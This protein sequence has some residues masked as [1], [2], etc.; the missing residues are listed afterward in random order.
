VLK[1]T[2]HADDVRT[3]GEAL[4]ALCGGRLGEAYREFGG[5]L[6]SA[7]GHERE[8]ALYRDPDPVLRAHTPAVAAVPADTPAQAWS[9]L[10]EDLR[11]AEL[12]DAVDRPDAWTDDH[13]R[14]AVDGMAAIHGAWHRRVANLRREPWIGTVRDT[15]VVEGMTPLWRALADHAAPLFAK[16]T[17]HAVPP[18]QRALIDCASAWR[19]ALDAA[20]Q[21]L[22][23][24]DF[25]P[26]NL[27]FKPDADGR[28]LCVFDWELATIG[29][30]MRDLAELLCFVSPAG[31]KSEW[32]HSLL[33]RHAARFSAGAGVHA[34]P[35]VWRAS[36]AAALAELL[37][38]RLSVYAMVHRVKPQPFLP[39]VVRTWTTLHSLF[40]VHG[41]TG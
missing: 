39:R 37:I 12:L 13:V 23:H 26:R 41:L 4:A 8:C 25:N 17:D 33:D 19:P 1:V 32:I 20:P 2:A 10:V 14:A 38:D 11:G 24:N 36:F 28:R 5:S 29:A 3:V 9:V 22:I 16:W 31:V 15:T 18:L 34:D 30:P 7:L 6:G 35:A 21:T 27:C 40:P